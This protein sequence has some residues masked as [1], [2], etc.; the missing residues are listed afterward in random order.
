MKTTTTIPET[1]TTVLETTIPEETITV[2]ETSTTVSEITTT[3]QQTTTSTIPE[4]STTILEFLTCSD[5]DEKDY[6]THG[7]VTASY[8]GDAYYLYEDKCVDETSVIEYFCEGNTLN[9]EVFECSEG[10]ECVRGACES[11]AELVK[12]SGIVTIDPNDNSTKDTDVKSIY[13]NYYVEPEPG[14]TCIGPDPARPGFTKCGCQGGRT[15]YV[16]VYWKWDWD[17]DKNIGTYS[18]SLTLKDDTWIAVS[19]GDSGYFITDC[20][21][22]RLLIEPGEDYTVN[23]E[24]TTIC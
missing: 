1:T 13:I 17:L 9:S 19:W 23:L 24:V 18:T 7:Y 4:L 15:G 8:G 2:E 20:V 5:S 22:E 21:C 10:M 16:P 14:E 12:I 3:V 6:Y 11:K